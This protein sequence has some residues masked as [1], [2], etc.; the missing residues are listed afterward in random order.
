MHCLPTWAIW[1][2]LVLFVLLS[3]VIAMFLAMAT[4]IV[5]GALVDAGAPGFALL[6]AGVCALILV[7]RLWRGMRRPALET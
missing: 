7:R 1:A 6:G 4:E 3:P 2:I 5:L